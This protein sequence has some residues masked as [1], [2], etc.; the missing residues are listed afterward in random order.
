MDVHGDPYYWS[1]DQVIAYFC[2][3]SFASAFQQPDVQAVAQILRENDISG[4]V[5]LSDVDKATLKDELAIRSFGQRAKIHKAILYLRGISQGYRQNNSNGPCEP[6]TPLPSTSAALLGLHHSINS[7]ATTLNSPMLNPLPKREPETTPLIHNHQSQLPRASPAR[8]PSPAQNEDEGPRKK[9]RLDLSQLH[10]EKKP[11]QTHTEK[12]PARTRRRY[13]PQRKFTLHDI[14]YGD[15]EDSDEEDFLVEGIEACRGQRIFVNHA[16]KAFHREPPQIVKARGKP[17]IARFPFRNHRLPPGTRA[18]FTLFSEED[19]KT[20]VTKE[21]LSDWPEFQEKQEDPFHD[22]LLK[23]YAPN[24]DDEP[25]PAYGDSGSEGGYD[26][27]LM[28]EIEEERSGNGG[29]EDASGALS[30]TTIDS[31][32]DES[33]IKFEGNFRDHKLPQY[34]QLLAFLLLLSEE[35]STGRAGCKNKECQDTKS[36]IAKGEL[37]LGS[38]IEAGQFQS[39]A[40]KHWGCVT[41]RQIASMKEVVGEEN[42]FNLLDGFDE[43]SEE[44]RTKI[45]EAVERGHVADEDWKGDVEV[46]RPGKAGFRVKASKKQKDE[47]AEE[48]GKPT[49]KAGKGRGK[50][51]APE[52]SD[53]S[54]SEKEENDQNEDA[55][56]VTKKAKMTKAKKA[57]AKEHGGEDTEEKEKAEKEVKKKAAPAKRTPKKKE[58]DEDENKGEEKEEEEK[59]KPAARASK[60]QAEKVDEKQEKKKAEK[61]KPATKAKKEEA[62]KDGEKKKEESKKKP[63]AKKAS[64]NDGKPAKKEEVKKAPARQTKKKTEEKKNEEKE[65]EEEEKQSAAKDATEETAEGAEGEKEEEKAK[66]TSTSSEE[67][68]TKDT[69]ETDAAEDKEE[70]KPEPKKATAAS[71]KPKKGKAASAK[72]N[73]AKSSSKEA[74]PERQ[75]RRSSR[76]K[77]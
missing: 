18:Y 49:K 58:Q 4:D 17:A 21:P 64:K 46:N 74:Q 1:V 55:E 2:E 7:P 53:T 56:P 10:T 38:W 69:A 52:A 3:S 29:N 12:R 73:K 11:S 60:R 8:A 23:K 63:A 32:I 67:T 36:K 22:Y 37:R 54:S 72:Q 31:I 61:K 34:L 41:P 19:G 45:K 35:A 30:S 43:I 28:R 39:W 6:T 76:N 77:N 20:V 13:M 24:K 66:E 44:N 15:E 57:T 51:S 68:T 26:S 16:L 70:D 40:W 42:D 50:R 75:L 71:E 25:L 47:E 9:R 62:E 27:D 48:A 59:K 33:I 5:L 65:E 14:Y